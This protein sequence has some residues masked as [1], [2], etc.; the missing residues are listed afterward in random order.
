[1]SEQMLIPGTATQSPELVANPVANPGSIPNANPANNS[2]RIFGRVHL[3]ID[4]VYDL[5]DQAT[6][7]PGANVTVSKVDSYGRPV[8]FAP[9]RAG[10]FDLA[11]LVQRHGG[12]E[13]RLQIRVPGHRGNWRACKFM[14][15]DS[16][17][18][19]AQP[20]RFATPPA[21]TP[22]P[23]DLFGMAITMMTGMMKASQEQAQAASQQNNLLMMKMMEQ[24]SEPRGMSDIESILK[25]ADRIASRQGNDEDAGGMGGFVGKA[26]AAMLAAPARPAAP[27]APAPRPQPKPPTAA[28]LPAA[29]NNDPHA[30]VAPGSLDPTHV[31]QPDP[32]TQ[33]AA[34]PPGDTTATPADLDQRFAHVG[35]LLVIVCA[36][37]AKDAER[38]AEM[39]ADI[40]GDDTAQQITDLP[41]GVVVKQLISGNPSLM[42]HQPFLV[43]VETELRQLYAD[44]AAED[45]TPPPVPPKDVQRDPIA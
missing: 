34:L 35:Q 27:A 9:M 37:P 11:S 28:A 15:G 24:K 21:T 1:M 19:E 40:L 32:S 39:I 7:M 4:E 8:A 14:A 33:P 17:T 38:T 41:E 16:P 3:D 10:D 43:S 29:P 44:D 26:L 25:L 2:E 23:T 18:P 6:G 31:E 22:A 30:L 5:L 36:A 42:A 45:V 12:G 13:Y 20:T